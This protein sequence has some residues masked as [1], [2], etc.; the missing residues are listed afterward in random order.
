MVAGR[1]GEQLLLLPAGPA[2]AADDPRREST[3]I[4]RDAERLMRV[5]DEFMAAGLIVNRPL[6]DETT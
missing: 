6:R 5:E 2:T 1:D 3:G 4:E